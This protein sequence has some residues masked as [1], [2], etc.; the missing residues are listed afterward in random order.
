MIQMR[1]CLRALGS[2]VLMGICGFTFGV[3]VAGRPLTAA[4]S[5]PLA[6]MFAIDTSEILTEAERA[7]TGVYEQVA[8]AVVS[9]TTAAESQDLGFFNTSTG[10]GFVVDFSG[11]IVTNY[12]V[13][14]GAERIEINMFDGTITEA[15]VVGTDPDSDLAVLK[16]NVPQER[17][18]PVRFANSDALRVGQTVLAIGNPFNNDWTLTSGIIS[19]LNRSIVGLNRFSIGGVIQTDAAINPGN[20]GGPL[21]NLQ[22]E[23]IGVNSQI[24]SEVR[25]NSGVGFAVPSN[26]VAKVAQTLIQSGSMRYSYLGISSRQI[27][28]DLIRSF[29]LPDNIRGVAVLQADLG[30]PA[31]QAG[32]QSISNASVD[33]ITALDGRPVKDFDEM[34]GWLAINTSP[35]Q[36][37]TLTV[38]RQGQVLSI[39]VTLA[40]R[41][42]R[43][44]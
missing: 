3:L 32:I 44:Q 16:I 14:E 28:L 15:S 12:H 19:A 1:G 33:I 24:E 36:T 18:R 29:N 20:S 23:V 2:G 43:I 38:Y 11:H 35:G 10:S 30:F 42:S 25:A 5:A 17:L 31:G 22:G 26:L 21:V 8:P 13:V 41:P 27:D 37:I 39:P 7:F 6:P 9:I 4:D 40:E 34:V